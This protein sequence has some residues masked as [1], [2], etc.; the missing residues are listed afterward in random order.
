MS[1]IEYQREKFKRKSRINPVPMLAV[2]KPTEDGRYKLVFE[3]AGLPPMVNPSGGSRNFWVIDKERKL[4]MAAVIGLVSV[5][6]PPEPLALVDI[7]CTRHSSVVPDPDGIV[8]GFK[9]VID[10]LVK[11]RV[12]VNDKLTNFVKFPNYQWSPAKQGEGKISV[13]VTEVNRKRRTDV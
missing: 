10:A 9:A 13:S 1:S 2:V 5:K 8:H 7:C 6:A 11:C 3:I 12:L 4:W